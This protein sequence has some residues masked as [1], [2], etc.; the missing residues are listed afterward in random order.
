MNCI[1]I[2]AVIQQREKKNG[3]AGKLS[4]PK[5]KAIN[6]VC[7]QAAILTRD[8]HWKEKHT[9][10]ASRAD[11]ASYHKRRRDKKNT[12]SKLSI[13]IIIHMKHII[14]VSMGSSR[15]AF[16]LQSANFLCLLVYKKSKCWP[17]AKKKALLSQTW[18]SGR[19]QQGLGSS[20]NRIIKPRAW[21]FGLVQA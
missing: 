1:R 18:L 12:K 13:H 8:Y 17:K 10:P 21:R 6:L 4:Q 19:N 9:F 15:A 16:L 7:T 3:I 11:N 14:Y 5:E 2:G 20:L